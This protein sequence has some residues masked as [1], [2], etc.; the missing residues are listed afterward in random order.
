MSTAASCLKPTLGYLA[1]ISPGCVPP[2]STWSSHQT[3]LPISV[4]A[5]YCTSFWLLRPKPQ[6]HPGAFCLLQTSHSLPE[7]ILLPLLT[8]DPESDHFSL[9]SNQHHRSPGLVQWLPTRAPCSTLPPSSL[10]PSQPAVE[11]VQLQEKANQFSFHSPGTIPHFIQ[12]CTGI[13]SLMRPASSISFDSLSYPSPSR[14]FFS[15]HTACLAIP[16][17]F[18]AFPC[19]FS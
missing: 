19:L 18:Q 13:H 3:E 15:S 7:Q 12:H 10:F 6:S 5:N 14:S 11:M 1:G 16:A 17:S 4:N 9:L 8:V 2:E